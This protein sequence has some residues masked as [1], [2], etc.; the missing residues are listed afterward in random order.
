MEED[1]YEKKGR[2]I[3]QRRKRFFEFTHSSTRSTILMLCAALA[4]LLIENTP[5][6]PNFAD[7]WNTTYVGL[8]FGEVAPQ[9][10]IGHFINDFL[11]AIFFLIVGLDIKFELTAGELRNPRKALL[12]LVAGV[13][14]AIFPAL[15]YL[16]FTA[17]QGDY[18]RG[19]GIPLSNDIAFCLGILALL[20]SRVPVGLRAFLSTC[21]IVDDVM[22]ILIIAVFYT[23]SLSIPW[24]LAGFGCFFALVFINRM[25]VNTLAPYIVIGL[26][27]WLTVYL[28]GVHATLAG[29]MLAITIPSH[30]Q[31]KTKNINEWFGNK[32]RKA[33][34]RYDPGEMD[35]AQKEYLNEV[36][37]I[38]RV[39]RMT[40]P[41]ITRL[42]HNIHTLVYFVVLPLFAFAN[43][44]VMF[45]GTDIVATMTH[46]VALGVF[47]GLLVAKPAGIFLTSLITVK[48]GLSDLPEG[49]SWGHMAG[50]SILG[51]VGFTMAIFVTNLAFTD[52]ALIATSKIAILAAS[53]IAGIVGFLILRREALCADCGD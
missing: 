39:S 15:L 44:S 14:G 11:M 51:G 10:S 31:I 18:L 8:S 45:V 37:Q 25:G 7:F 35:I 16:A 6:L 52:P 36:D 17:G 19:W 32:A 33:E 22:A 41:P 42:N 38:A 3:A 28:S 47:F 2:K 50:A 40:I 12:P 20:G 4:A 49:V 24:L 27:M 43:A 29:V 1:I 26:V 46:P 23:S 48:V 21:T 13:G 53:F 30:T 34:E 5:V 9:I